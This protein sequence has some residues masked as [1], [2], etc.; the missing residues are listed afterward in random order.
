MPGALVLHQAGETLCGISHRRLPFA[1]LPVGVFDEAAQFEVMAAV[2]AQAE[3][4]IDPD[5]Q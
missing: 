4:G 5:F 3:D 2:V 1:A